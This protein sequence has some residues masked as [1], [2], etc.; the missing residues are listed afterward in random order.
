MNYKYIYNTSI[1]YNIYAQYRY[2]EYFFFK[3]IIFS[4][5]EIKMGISDV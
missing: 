5:L 3:Y 4:A 1:I 2:K